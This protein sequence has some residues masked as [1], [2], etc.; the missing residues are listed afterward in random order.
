MQTGKD[1]SKE[2]EEMNSY[3]L[4][5]NVKHNFYLG[6]VCVCVYIHI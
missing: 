4:M 3:Q 5:L 6:V 1:K 2:K